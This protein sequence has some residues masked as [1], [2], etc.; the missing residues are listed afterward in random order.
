MTETTLRRLRRS[1]NSLHRSG[2]L[3]RMAGF[4]ALGG[5][6]WAMSAAAAVWPDAGMAPGEFGSCSPLQGDF[7]CGHGLGCACHLLP[8]PGSQV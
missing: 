7:G 5:S 1:I 2:M 4:A 8:E 3:V 6:F